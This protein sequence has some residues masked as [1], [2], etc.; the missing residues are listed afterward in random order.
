MGSGCLQSLMLCPLVGVPLKQVLSDP[1]DGPPYAP[2]LPVLEAGECWASETWGLIQP[3]QFQP[4][5][6]FLLAS[7]TPYLGLLQRTVSKRQLLAQVTQYLGWA[8]KV[9][10]GG[11][12]GVFQL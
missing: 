3:R 5:L 2:G 1:V 11:D 6:A 9:G 8:A 10:W 12:A 4:P 7:S